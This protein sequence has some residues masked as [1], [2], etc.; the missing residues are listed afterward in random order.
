MKTAIHPTFYEDALVTCACGNTF[1]T[2]STQKE[3]KTEI[4][5]ACHPFYTGQQRMVDTGGQVERFMKRA[6]KSGR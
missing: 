6:A 1:T 4:C 3:L 2:G 5:S